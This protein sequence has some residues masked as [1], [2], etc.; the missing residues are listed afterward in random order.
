MKDAGGRGM[1]ARKE[2]RVE[3]RMQVFT[4]KIASAR[5]KRRDHLWGVVQDAIIVHTHA[6]PGSS[7]S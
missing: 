7:V 2:V 6:R 5:K 4:L 1:W 3:D